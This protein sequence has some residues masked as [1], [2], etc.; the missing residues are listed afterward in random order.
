M[1]AHSLPSK[2]VRT[3]CFCA[4]RKLWLLWPPAQAF[5]SKR[6]ILD[7]LRHEFPHLEPRERP[8]TVVQEAGDVVFVPSGW[9]HGILNLK[10]GL[11]LAEEFDLVRW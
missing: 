9:A 8:L 2:H 3:W 1:S 6:P 11:G 4:G 7:Y 10:E 5:Y